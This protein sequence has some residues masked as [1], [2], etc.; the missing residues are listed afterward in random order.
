[1][2]LTHTTLACSYGMAVISSTIGQTQFFVDMDLA[3]QGTPGYDHTA[4]IIGGMNGANSA[5][6]ALGALFT[7]WAADKYGRLRSIQLGAVIL[8]VGAVLCAASVNVAMFM[9]A[10]VCL[11]YI[12]WGALRANSCKGTCDCW[13]WH[14]LPYHRKHILVWLLYGSL[15]MC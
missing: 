6:S 8:I 9:V 7:V 3:Q 11:S 12:T 14:R 10:S 4:N 15:N 13:H 2:I 5:G 1:V